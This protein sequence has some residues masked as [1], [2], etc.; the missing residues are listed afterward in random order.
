MMSWKDSLQ[1]ASFRGVPFQ[2]EGNDLS[3]GRRVQ[4]HEYPQ[5]DT[6]YTEDLGRATRE[7][8]LTAF[9]IGADYLAAR[10]SLLAAC[11]E[12][13]PGT[14]VHPWY[15]SLQVVLKSSRVSESRADGG[16]ARFSL[17]FVEAGELAFPKAVDS[18]AAQVKLAS[19][20]LATAAIA[21]FEAKFS[22]AA[23]PGWV[24][25]A[26][27]ADVTAALNTVSSTLSTVAG[28]PQ[29][30]LAVLQSAVGTLIATPAALAA[31][32][33]ALFSAIESV[34][35]SYATLVATARAM[36]DGGAEFSDPAPAAVTASAARAQLVQNT[37]AV[38][39][40]MRR[41]CLVKAAE[42][43]AAMPLP[44]YDDA[45]ELRAALSA[46]LDADAVTASDA[47]YPALADLRVKVHK[48]VTARTRDSARLDTLT[49]PE[50]MPA[51]ALAYDLY[52]DAGR[53]AEVVARNRI[54]H[55]G[56]V[57]ANPILVLSR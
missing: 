42:S 48:D 55:P 34:G 49:P 25:V 36:I 12:A 54:R 33:F 45:I 39:A 21:D 29:A 9:V 17:T 23:L 4:V 20:A 56:F 40:L 31:Q 32:V 53:D 7:I 5:R 52:E 2:V 35:Q 41:A 46:A 43:V 57:P 37:A 22:T 8:S 38:R 13:G 27:L 6:P 3:A 44:V 1:P 24:G 10:D 18:S 15:G 26:A 11:E 19:A 14:L 51:L 28:W 50:P 16:M 47:A 30:K